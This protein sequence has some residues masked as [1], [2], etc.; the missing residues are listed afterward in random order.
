MIDNSF[1]DF[2]GDQKRVL[3]FKKKEYYKLAQ[4]NTQER[5]GSGNFQKI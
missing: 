5:K 2:F 3:E 1:I 4:N